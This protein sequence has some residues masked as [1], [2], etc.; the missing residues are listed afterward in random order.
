MI[1]S[2]E[3]VTGERIQNV[4]DYYLGYKEDFDYNPLISSQKTKHLY[5]D[6][7]N[8]I[9]DNPPIIYC[10]TNRINILQTKL[11]FFINKFLLITHNSDDDITSDNVIVQKILNSDKIIAW[12]GQNVCFYH[13]K[14]HLLPIGFANSMWVHGNLSLFDNVDFIKNLSIKTE[15][16]YFNFTIN[17]NAKK[18]QPCYNIFINRLPFLQMLQPIDNLLRLQRYEFCICPEGNGVD[19][20]RLWECIYLKTVPIVINS[21]FT[22]TLQRY[23][24]PLM[25][26]EKWEDLDCST[27][28]Y[29]NYNFELENIKNIT[30]LNRLLKGI[31]SNII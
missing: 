25:I 2:S 31:K 24:I 12:Y 4:S 9:F 19:S 11:D 10:Y 27:L 30:N 22:K 23:N 21:E 29:N 6:N 5:F 13:P 3:I 15:K 7:I 14:L 26:L 16:I 20:H 17:T 1:N 8:Y 18:R 28:D